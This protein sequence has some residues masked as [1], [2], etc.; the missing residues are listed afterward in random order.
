MTDWDREKQELLDYYETLRDQL[1]ALAEELSG[2][3]NSLDIVAALVRARRALEVIATELCEQVLER[4]RGTEPLAGILARFG[5]K[6]PAN[7]LTSMRNLNE[8][9][10]L[11]AH[12]KKSATGGTVREACLALAT[13][14]NWYVVEYKQ[15][16]RSPNS[17][18]SDTST[19]TELNPYRGLE[20]FEEKDADRF[21]GRENLLTEKLWP[22][23]EAL[24]KAPPR[25]LALVGPS[26]SGKSSLARAGL[27]PLLKRKFP[28]CRLLVTTPTRR[29]LEALARALAQQ[30]QPDDPAPVGKTQEFL[31]R[32]EM[33]DQG[34]RCV[35]DLLYERDSAPRVL[36]VDQ[37]EEVFTLGE[38]EKTSER[39]RYLANLLNAISDPDSHL[40][41]LLTLRSDFL[42]ESQ[43][44]PAF[45]QALSD[46]AHLVPVLD[47]DGLKRAIAEPARWV[48]RPLEDGVVQLLIEQSEG[49]EGALPLLQHAL[50]EIW[51]GLQQ[52]KTAAATLHAIGGVGGALAG[53]AQAIYRRLPENE[54][55]IAQ[56]AFLKLVQLGEGGPD[57]RRRRVPLEDLVAQGE[58][59]ATV[60]SILHR[61]ADRNA[62]FLT[63]GQE[64]NGH[65]SVEI[66]HDALIQHWNELRE[67]L[68][69][70]RDDLRL[71]SRLEAAAKH[72]KAAGRASGL[73]WRRPDLD[74]LKALATRRQA[75]FTPVQKEFHDAAVAEERRAAKIKK[76]TATALVVTTLVASAT[77]LVASFKW[78]E[79]DQ[80]KTRAEAN[81]RQAREAVDNFYRDVS[82]STLLGRPGLAT[83]RQQLMEKALKYYQDIAAQRPGD[84]E[85]RTELANTF[86]RMGNIQRS[87]KDRQN[88]EALY[89][90]AI[91]YFEMLAR[92]NPNK[93]EYQ[94]SLAGIHV[95]LSKLL[96]ENNDIVGM[97]A[98]IQKAFDLWE[99]LVRTYPEVPIY[100]NK[101]IRNYGELSK[102]LGVSGDKAGAHEVYQKVIDLW[103]RL[104]QAYPNVSEYKAGLA[105][106][107]NDFNIK[108]VISQD[109]ESHSKK[110]AEENLDSL[111]GLTSSL[112]IG[113]YIW[114]LCCEYDSIIMRYTKPTNLSL[115]SKDTTKALET[116]QKAIDLGEQLVQEHPEIQTYQNQLA[117]SYH[118]IGNLLQGS[119]DIA[120]AQAVYK[121]AIVLW[122]SL[123]R[124]HPEVQAYRFELL[125]NHYFLGDL[126]DTTGD[127]AGTQ[128]VWQQGV[129]LYGQLVREHPEM[130]V[131]QDDL[132]ASYNQLGKLLIQVSGDAIG[133][134]E[135]YQEKV[136]APLER[137]AQVHPE[138]P[139][140]QWGLAHNYAKFGI[141]LGLEDKAGARAAYQK[142]SEISA[143]LV[144]AFPNGRNY[145]TT[146]EL[147]EGN[148]A[149]LELFAQH[150]R[151]AIA[152]ATRGLE[153][154]P[155]DYDDIDSRLLL[156][157]SYLLD[158]QYEKALAI[159]T[160]CKAKDDGESCAESA[161]KFFK[162]LRAKGIDHPDMMK[163]EQL[164]SKH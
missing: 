40:Y 6:I 146:W 64:A 12:P 114:K 18:A 101:L 145:R 155:H 120:K 150:P 69:A 38:K 129:N 65:E 56:R 32:L 81:L 127:A 116:C 15:I 105:L 102:S 17:T 93:P 51:Q 67:W 61:F 143:S 159:Y 45:N 28:A 49:R 109:I 162:S 77:T 106:S 118:I 86:W 115:D 9:G 138:V 144:Q 60:R 151:E 57:T 122:E 30:F 139:A 154:H 47:D 121:K 82:E 26:G 152:A 158:N 13:V 58:D 4:P 124:K 3:L 83:L 8:L 59:R 37:F 99:Q 50:S 126:L 2:L 135:A 128:S 11:G 76:L 137:L 73:L 43:S 153:A 130:Q 140:Y 24:M 161:L 131:Y 134:R 68:S 84:L 34:L 157:H 27:L 54:Q 142:S 21:F 35:A 52:G 42:A 63:F 79:A 53:R 48:G 110:H 91:T 104:A 41:L 71:L 119:K 23:F 94:D 100:R 141:F 97:R 55:V 1:V 72:W 10:N 78:W 20:A 125:V 14:L 107:Y 95:D 117:D 133:A 147:A 111:G 108:F 103:E 132:V 163:I 113:N 160:E 164:L 80:Q 112:M 39:Q 123:V 148:L 98:E 90:Q 85:I 5:D 89:H 156:A 29:P 92:E 22:A 25:L 66:T 62:R 74:L 46:H 70:N 33:D 16:G 36:L 87:L 75:A 7:V 44:Y 19:P 96:D 136:L 88:A 31:Q 149:I